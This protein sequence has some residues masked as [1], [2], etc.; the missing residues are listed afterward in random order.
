MYEGGIFFCKNC[1][2]DEFKPAMLAELQRDCLIAIERRG[3][4]A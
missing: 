4:E 1:P 2:L 3:H